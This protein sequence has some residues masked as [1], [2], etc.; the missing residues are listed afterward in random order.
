MKFLMNIIVVLLL[1]SMFSGCTETELTT[2][3]DSGESESIMFDYAPLDLT[4][5]VFIEPLGAM[6][7]NHVTPIDH[8]YYSALDH[9][10]Q[11]A[12]QII[13]DVYSPASGTVTQIQHMSSLP[14]DDTTVI[15]DYRIVIEHTTTISSIYIH[16]DTLSAKIAAVAPLPGEY[17]SVNVDVLAG[18]II[19]YYKGTIDYNVVDE[20]I[21]LTGFV[22]PDSYQVEPWKIHTPDP[23]DYFH[24]PIKSQLIEKCLRTAEPVGGKIDYDID[25]RLIG[26]WFKENTNGYAGLGQENY[27]VGHLSVV[28]HNVDPEHVIVSLGSYE[29]QPRQFGVKSNSPDPADVSVATGQILYELV[30]YDYYDGDVRWDRE[31]LVKGLK[32]RNGDFVQGVVLFQLIEDRKLKVE[33]FPYATADSVGSFTANAMIYVR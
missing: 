18:E 31:S 11:D 6:I 15:D 33:I 25:G 8:Q 26:S 10:L 13:V 32:L 30:D 19:G 9:M 5:V 7:G 1:I 4:N 28:Y 2:E 29:N 21:V 14:G 20:D 27:W 22:N 3:E 16:L 24:E 17:A 12:A 23:F